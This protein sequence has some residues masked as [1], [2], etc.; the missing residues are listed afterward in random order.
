[1]PTWVAART[2]SCGIRLE[3][4]AA[5]LGPR[6]EE[7]RAVTLHAEE[8]EVRPDP[9]GV[10][11]PV[12]GLGDVA[13]G[14]DSGH[15]R[16]RL[17]EAA[18]VRMVVG[19]PVDHPRAAVAQRDEAGGREDP[20]LAHPAADELPAAPGAPDDVPAGRRARCRPGNRGPSRCRS[21]TVSAGPASSSRADSERDDR[22]PEPRAVHVERDAALV[23]DRGDGLG[24]GD[25]E[26]LAHRVGVGVLDGDEAGDR[27]VDVGRVAERVADLVEVH[28]P[29]RPLGQGADRRADDDRVTRGLVEDDVALA[30]GDRLLA[31]RRGGPAG[32]RGCPSCRRQRTGRPPCR[33]ARPLAPRGR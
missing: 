1:M 25:R 32:R 5:G 10:E 6:L 15:R 28:R 22:V 12:A 18:G 4:D 31:A 27:L 20:G 2:W 26:R 13:R 21:V 33:A 16:E 24:V 11:R 17:G 23:R 8:H 29:V 30:A 7:R 19:E 9:L 3:K 14:D